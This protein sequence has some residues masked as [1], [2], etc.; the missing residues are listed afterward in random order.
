MKKSPLTS[1]SLTLLEHGHDFVG[2]V[3]KTLK[4]IEVNWPRLKK[5]LELLP[6]ERWFSMAYAGRKNDEATIFLVGPSVGK[7]LANSFNH[8]CG[9]CFFPVTSIQWSV[10]IVYSK[11][12]WTDFSSMPS[13]SGRSCGYI[14]IYVHTHILGQEMAESIRWSLQIGVRRF[15][16]LTF[17]WIC[18]ATC[19]S[20]L[21]SSKRELE[22]IG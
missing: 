5:Q 19:G 4:H 10:G 21:F 16:R 13:P 12:C 8:N 15:Q 3:K 6:T 2:M 18:R 22:V 1:C 7:H 14:Y 17:R 11:L 9:W 20:H